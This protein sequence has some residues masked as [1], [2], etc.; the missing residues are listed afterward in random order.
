MKKKFPDWFIDGL[1]DEH[2]G[3]SVFVFNKVCLDY[4]INYELNKI[5]KTENQNE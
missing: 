5:P 4:N 2:R 1:K 3:G